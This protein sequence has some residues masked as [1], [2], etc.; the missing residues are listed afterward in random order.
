MS[1]IA[2]NS[3]LEKPIQDSKIDLGNDLLNAW[4]G[5]ALDALDII[6]R[7]SVSLIITSPPYP[8]VPQPEEEY[9]TFPDPSDFVE[10]HDFLT[11]V[12]SVCYNLLEDLGRLVINIYD[13]PTGEEGMIP[14][15]SETVNR[16]LSLG[17]VLRETYIWVK[18]ASYSPPSGS[19]PYPKG[20]LSGNTYEPCL[21]FQ[22]PLQFS[23]RRKDPDDC[24]QSIKDASELGQD[25]HAWLMDPVWHLPTDRTGRQLGHP[26]T[27]PEAL[28]S[29]FIR[30]Y[31]YA[32][33]AVFD[34][35]L[36]S[37]TTIASASKLGRMGLGTE[38]L[39]RLH[40]NPPKK[41]QQPLFVLKGIQMHPTPIEDR[42][43]ENTEGSRIQ[44][45]RILR[46][47]PVQ[48]ELH[49]HRGHDRSTARVLS[50]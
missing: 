21:V 42:D 10:C 1:S 16:C 9:A 46:R 38:D 18:G 49:A 27:F 23:Q 31:S 13:I 12:W 50:S 40:R 41:I 35:F 33:D 47:L 25:E 20:V 7:S 2:I 26:F 6:E 37:G 36:G 22:K 29:R 11:D 17:F 15:V 28:I 5:S 32:G 34:P 48:R 39:I 30:L 24:P 4:H 3:I 8:G 44:T 19:W 43:I 14:N 45:D